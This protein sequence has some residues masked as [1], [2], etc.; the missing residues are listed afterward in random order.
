MLLAAWPWLSLPQAEP[1]SPPV[2]AEAAPPA[3]ATWIEIANTPD[4][5]ILPPSQKVIGTWQENGLSVGASTVAGEQF[6]ST[7]E[8]ATAP[9][10]ID[11][12]LASLTEER[13]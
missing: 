11:A 12:T 1:Q 10:L 7:V 8:M 2:L 6:W 4:A 3:S 9:S 5:E 13:P